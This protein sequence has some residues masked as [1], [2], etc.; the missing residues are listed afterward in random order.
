MIDGAAP[1]QRAST[2]PA[3]TNLSF[4]KPPPEINLP[5]RS[6]SKNLGT[7][8]QVPPLLHHSFNNGKIIPSE[9]VVYTLPNPHSSATDSNKEWQEKNNL[10]VGNYMESSTPFCTPGSRQCSTKD[11]PM[12]MQAHPFP[13]DGYLETSNPPP[14]SPNNKIISS[15][16]DRRPTVD[17]VQTSTFGAIVDLSTT[18]NQNQIQTAGRPESH[19]YADIPSNA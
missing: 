16:N 4:P 5:S 8:P 18:A 1:P 19:V 17:S 7:L 14:Y 9:N 2:L 11:H 3:E 12:C 13:D 10:E 15:L 6:S